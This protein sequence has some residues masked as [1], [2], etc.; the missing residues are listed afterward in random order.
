MQDRIAA[1]LLEIEAI[2]MDDRL[3][4]EDRAALHGAQQALRNALDPNTWQPASL[5]F[6]RLGARPT[7][8][9]PAQH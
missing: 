6:Y 2:L 5:T 8:A 1:E 7:L 4:E 3:A 9:G